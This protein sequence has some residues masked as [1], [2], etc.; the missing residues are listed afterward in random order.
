MGR[1]HGIEVSRDVLCAL[2]VLDGHERDRIAQVYSGEAAGCRDGDDDGVDVEYRIE[3]G[4]IDGV[5]MDR[6]N[7]IE[8]CVLYMYT[9]NLYLP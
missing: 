2:C 8:A 9:G 4:D 1:R 5:D 3:D 6:S 7:S